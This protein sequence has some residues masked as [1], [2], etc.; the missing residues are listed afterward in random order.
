MKNLLTAVILLGSLFSHAQFQ[1]YSWETQQ[2]KVLPNGDLEWAPQEFQFVT[3]S[4]VR[5]IDYENGD[6]S[7]DGLTKSTPWKHHPWDEEATDNAANVYGIHTY[8]F[9][10]G[11]VY[12]GTLTKLGI[13]SGKSGNPV[14][15]TSDPDWGEGEAAIYGS[16]KVE[17]GWIQADSLSAPNIPNP[18]MV[19][20]KDIGQ[21]ENATK[22]VCE[23]TDTSINRI[24]LARSPN[25]VNTPEEPMKTW[26]SFTG[27]TT[28]G[29]NLLLT[30]VNHFVEDEV[31]HYKGGDVWAIQGIPQVTMCALWKQK[32][33]DYN[34]ASS[35]I[36]VSNTNFGGKDCKY[37]VENTPFLLDSPGEYYYDKITG[38]IF[39]RLEGDRDP[40]KTTI[41]VA[42]KTK[43]LNTGARNYVQ[44]SGLTFGFTTC[45]DVRFGTTDG[46]ATLTISSSNVVV[47]NCKF[48]YLNGGIMA[49]GSGRNIVISD[50]EMNYMDDFSIFTYGPDEVSILRNKIFESGTRHLSRW[51]GS[52]PAVAG[53]LS[54]GEIAGNIIEH[55]WGSGINFTWGK[56][57]SSNADIPFI[58]GFVH[59]N[60]ASHTLQGVND[61]GGIEAWQGGPVYTYNNI[62]EDAQGWHYDWWGSSER[63]SLG[64]AIYLDGSF[65][66]YVFNNIVKG[67]AWNLNSAAYMHVLGFYNF[68]VHNV[69]YNVAELTF[70]G[71]GNLSPDGQN[72]YLANV[73]DSTNLQ[74]NH[75]TRK[76]GIPFESYANNI[77]SGRSFQGTFITNKPG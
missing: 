54:V 26:W 70:S 32:I 52:I 4:S 21:L 55:S 23:V 5:Y 38:R 67:R 65:K 51:Y 61:Y 68:W 27:K 53:N 30:D 62:S 76:S 37:Y 10:R 60:K 63:V 66:N 6:D 40:N 50:N 20:Y 35:S 75:T 48:Q 39:I 1:K 28:S 3:G 29:D 49:N 44:I 71:D 77:F 45:D 25:Y 22:V 69:A 34:P 15:L 13:G 8:I 64:Y 12:R 31:D 43:L 24:Y 56:G 14:R 11:V 33:Q 36:L 72:Y 47:K 42:S 41:E 17:D 19:W 7:N 2:A 74:F 59:H 58:R 18:E 46:Q 57:G 9:K 16:V 73:S